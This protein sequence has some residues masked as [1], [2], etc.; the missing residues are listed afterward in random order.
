VPEATVN[1]HRYPRPREDN[2]S[3][4]R[5]AYILRYDFEAQAL[6]RRLKEPSK[7]SLSQW[8]SSA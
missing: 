2:V 1:E 7:Q 4:R 8:R 5:L 6:L 3:P